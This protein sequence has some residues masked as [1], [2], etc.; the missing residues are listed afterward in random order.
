MVSSSQ[1]RKSKK[2]FSPKQKNPPSQSTASMSFPISI[3]RDL[4]LAVWLTPNHETYF[5]LGYA[6]D[7]SGYF[8]QAR[9]NYLQ[10]LNLNPESVEAQFNLALVFEAEENFE[11][12]YQAYISVIEMKSRHL[13]AAFGNVIALNNITYPLD[14]HRQ[15]EILRLYRRQYENLAIEELTATS[16]FK[17][18]Q[19]LRVGFVSAD[20]REHPV[21]YFLESTLEQIRLNPNL[22]SRLSL[23]AYHNQA[24]QDDFSFRLH[25][26]F[27]AWYRVDGWTDDHL[28]A[29]IKRDQID[30]LIDLSGHTRGHRLPVFAKRAAPLQ[31]S[32]LGYWGSTGLTTIDYLIADPYCVPKSE[33][34]WYSEKIWRLPHLRYC[35]S[36]PESAPE[37]ASPPCLDRHK[38]VFGCYQN[39]LKCW[40]RIFSACP[41]ARLRIQSKDLDEAGAKDKLLIRIQD[42]GINPQQID[43]IGKMPRHEYLASY[44]EVDILLDTFHYSGGTTTAEALWMGVPTLT[45]T[46]PSMLGRQGE[47]LMVNAGLSD[48][49]AQSEDEYVKKA[50]D[51]ANADSVQR[52]QLAT[53]RQRMR[54]QVKQSPVFNAEQF[55]SE[56][57]DAIFK[58]WEEKCQ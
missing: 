57:V 9:E 51:W 44:A 12:A 38:I 27:D 8:A 40:S 58:I 1:S 52:Q 24:A 50:I 11:C 6:F 32:W 55:T 20:L 16:E 7:K 53:L 29:Q 18:H 39:L 30:I 43:F 33:E 56:F 37:V 15:L 5:H 35:F 25:E 36:A 22:S 49:I 46:M 54:E 26:N 3:H 23:T 13:E 28:R 48:W 14:M 4:Q 17:A 10:A 31:V 47:A 2:G 41:D 42:A 19:P 45:L 34:S 21:G